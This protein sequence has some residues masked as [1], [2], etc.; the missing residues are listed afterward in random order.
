MFP[1][2]NLKVIPSAKQQRALNQMTQQTTQGW[3]IYVKV[4]NTHWVAPCWENIRRACLVGDVVFSTN[5]ETAW[6]C[7]CL[8]ISWT[9]NLILSS[10]FLLLFW[11]SI[12]TAVM[13]DTGT[14]RGRRRWS[15]PAVLGVR[16]A[17]TSCS[18]TD[19]RMSRPPRPVSQRPPHPAW[20]FPRHSRSRTRAAAPAWVTARPD[21]RCRNW[22]IW[23]A[24]AC[25]CVL[26]RVRACRFAVSLSCTFRKG[27]AERL[28]NV[29]PDVAL[30][31]VSDRI[32]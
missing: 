16:T 27:R 6:N 11:H 5:D 23:R 19:A 14:L 13:F 9:Q 3:S 32:I 15:W 21:E 10:F 18:N 28:M 1:L 24:P 20:P 25:V 12:S 4:T 26:A 30:P 7:S 31:E 29:L 8:I 17:S 22:K 2:R